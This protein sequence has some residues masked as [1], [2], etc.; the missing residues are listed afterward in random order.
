MLLEAMGIAR[1]IVTSALEEREK[2]GIKIRQPL[3]VLRIPEDSALSEEL[4]SIIADE[5]NVKRIEKKG[6]TVTLDVTI[7]EELRE[8][9]VIREVRRALQGARKVANL[10]PLDIAEHAVVTLATQDKDIVTTYLAQLARETRV[11]HIEIETHGTNGS[12]SAIIR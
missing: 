9:G 3:S 7:T 1:S 5:L 2:A 11:R 6:S 4:F 12:I 10:K 8:E